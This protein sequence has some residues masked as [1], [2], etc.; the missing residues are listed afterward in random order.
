MFAGC[1]TKLQSISGNTSCLLN[2]P[3]DGLRLKW[4]MILECWFIWSITSWKKEGWVRLDWLFLVERFTVIPAFIILGRIPE[5]IAA[6]TN[7]MQFK[8]DQT[9]VQ[10]K[11]ISVEFENEW[12]EK[13]VPDMIVSSCPLLWRL[14]EAEQFI[15]RQPSLN[16]CTMGTGKPLTVQCM[17]TSVARATV[18]LS[19][20]RIMWSLSGTPVNQHIKTSTSQK[21]YT[22]PFNPSLSKED[23]LHILAFHKHKWNI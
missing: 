11:I 20:P 22:H 2:F 21:L 3:M 8:N 6:N 5:T 13:Q 15:R 14:N 17:E 4:H 18:M 19:G 10:T 12:K 23:L 16:Q 1:W 9:Y 7:Y